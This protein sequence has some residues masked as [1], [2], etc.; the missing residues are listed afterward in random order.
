MGTCGVLLPLSPLLQALEYLETAFVRGYITPDEVRVES[1]CCVKHAPAHF[2][3]ACCALV[4]LYGT[5][6]SCDTLTPCAWCVV[7]GAWCVVCVGAPVSAV[8]PELHV[9][10]WANQVPRGRAEGRRQH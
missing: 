8:H 5:Q 7:R 1:S 9:P 2:W 3:A 6:Q 4:S 10:D